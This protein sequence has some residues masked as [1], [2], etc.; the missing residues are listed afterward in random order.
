MFFKRVFSLF[1]HRRDLE[2]EGVYHAGDRL[3]VSPPT[4]VNGSQQSAYV[5]TPSQVHS[6]VNSS[7]ALDGSKKVLNGAVSQPGD[8]YRV[9]L[10]C[11]LLCSAL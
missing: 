11:V 4:I 1:V 8:H 6:P 2:R 7:L 9:V 10:N 3:T 5:P